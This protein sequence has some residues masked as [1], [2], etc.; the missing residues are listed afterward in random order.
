MTKL[1][2]RFNGPFKVVAKKGLAYT[3]NLSKKMRAHPEFYVGL[4][5]PY[6]DPAQVS[7]EALAPGRQVAAGR[8]RVAEREGQARLVLLRLCSM[9]AVNATITWNALWHD[10]VIRAIPN[11]L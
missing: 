6:Q 9:S 4:L 2:P 1:R 11:I 5:K 10:I 3:L 7:V 8:K